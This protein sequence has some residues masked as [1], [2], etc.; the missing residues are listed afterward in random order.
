MSTLF[1]LLFLLALVLLIWGLIAPATL[2]KWSRKPLTRRDAGLGF[3]IAALVFFVL[4]GVTAPKASETPVAQSN[5][6]A[7]NESQTKDTEQKKVAAVSTEIVTETQPIP[8]ESTTV[9]DSSMPQGTS[10]VTITGKNG[11]KTLTYQVTYN[12]GVQTDK[13]LT[14]EEITTPPVAQVTSVGVFVKPAA[15]AP[16]AQ[17]TPSQS[18]CDPN[19]TGACVPNVY[20]ADVD[21]GGGSGNG[22]YY[23]YGTVHVVGTDRYDLDRDHDGY[24]CE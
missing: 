2:S 18:N 6:A 16:A 5:S 13:K 7:S 1:V 17:P 24:G 12:D 20:P 8:F 19:Y 10:K 23:V 22:P 3:G 15:Q 4:T 14:K 21:C 11:V 9:N